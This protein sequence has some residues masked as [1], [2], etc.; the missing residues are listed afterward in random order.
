[1]AHIYLKTLLNYCRKPSIKIR[2][3]TLF[4]YYDNLGKMN[5]K[6]PSTKTR[7]K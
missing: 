1:M 7:L 4:H 6:K 3:V 2:I 5:R